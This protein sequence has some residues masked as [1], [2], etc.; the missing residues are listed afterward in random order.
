VLEAELS[1]PNVMIELTDKP[2]ELLLKKGYDSRWAR[3]RWRG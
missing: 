2:R 1:D 3:G